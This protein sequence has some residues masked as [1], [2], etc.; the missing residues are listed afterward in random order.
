MIEFFKS[1]GFAF[2][3]FPPTEEDLMMLNPS[4]LKRYRN[5]KNIIETA[6]LERY[7]KG[8]TACNNVLA[9]N[10]QKPTTPFTQMLA[11]MYADLTF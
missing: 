8:K 2:K 5:L 10:G 1:Y 6:Y 9:H 3:I 4:D 7:K 11:V